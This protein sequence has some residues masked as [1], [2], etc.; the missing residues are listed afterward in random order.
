VIDRTGKLSTARVPE[1]TD[2]YSIEPWEEIA[3][4]L[5]RR[6]G[7]ATS[8]HELTDVAGKA[9]LLSRRFYHSGTKRTPF[10]SAIAMTGAKDGERGPNWSMP[11]LSTAPMER[12]M[13][14]RC[15]RMSS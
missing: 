14:R 15:T 5:A 13:R 3:L 10:L 11:S 4:R 8:H 12:Q 7:V 6:A 2:E 9:V 1:D